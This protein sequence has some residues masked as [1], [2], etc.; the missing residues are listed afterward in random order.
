MKSLII[1]L[2]IITSFARAQNRQLAF[3]GAEGFGRYT[4]G[5]RGGKVL[6][7]TNLDDDGP[8]SLRDTVR[9]KGARTIIFTVSGMIISLGHSICPLKKQIINR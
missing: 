2:L 9:Q 1:L 7:V 3:P 5:G 8:G 4:T 6:L